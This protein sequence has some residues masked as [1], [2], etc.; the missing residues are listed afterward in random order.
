M[1][2][3][4]VLFIITSIAIACKPKQEVAKSEPSITQKSSVNEVELTVDEPRDT[5]SLLSINSD[6]TNDM[7]NTGDPY[8]IES[9]KIENEILW[10]SLSY[11]GGCEEHEFKMLFNNAYQERLDNESGQSSLISLTLQHQGNN[12]RCRSIVRQN[13]RFDLKSIKNMGYKNLLINLN[14][15]EEQLI[16]AY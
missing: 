3:I 8:T 14:G 15:W 5:T 7:K 13:I 9:A 11:G 16:F 6:P 10:L 2:R 12:D 1:K 4:I